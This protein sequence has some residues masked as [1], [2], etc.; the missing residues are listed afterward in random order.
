MV[1]TEAG[2]ILPIAAL[3]DFLI[4][5]PV[6]WLHPVQVMGWAIAGYTK[7]VLTRLKNPFAQKIAGVCLGISLI[8]MSGLV[9]WAI[10]EAA[11]QIY[12]F[13]G[14]AVQVILLASCFAARSLR[15]AAE[16][17]LKPLQMGDLEQARSILSRYVGR[18]TENLSEAEVLRAVLET[19]TEN[20][21]DGVMAPLFYAL[22]GA[23]LPG[24]GSVP[25]AMAYKAAS[26]LDSM[27]G[28]REAPYTYIGWFSAKL[29]DILTWVPCRLTVLTISLLSGQ[30]MHVWKICLRDAPKDPS[31]NSGWS[32]CAYAAAL[33][34]QVGGVNWYRGVAKPKPLLGDAVYPISPKAIDQAI[35]LT[36]YAALIW[37]I[38]GVSGSWAAHLRHLNAP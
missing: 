29:E 6:G 17:V 22:I 34:V 26:T 27:V 19:V 35:S 20:A 25:L 23:L 30:T 24:V 10:V 32:E 3:L 14:I 37:L 5:D 38:I 1:V 8:G 18:D 13:L 33:G 7:Q 11:R 12:P 16:A 28:Y 2:L 31:P 15:N 36:R 21:T 9:S 4:G